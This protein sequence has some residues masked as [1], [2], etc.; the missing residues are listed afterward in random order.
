MSDITR[1]QFLKATA[2]AAAGGVLGLEEF[3]LPKA[4]AAQG[5]AGKQ[6][7]GDVIS[8]PQGGG[9]LRGIGETFKPDLFTGTANFSFPIATSP[10]REGFGP[11]L[12]LQYSSGNGNGLFGLGWTLSIP[13]VSRKTEKG[14]PTY[15]GNDTFL[16]SGSEDLVEL[17]DRMRLEGDFRVRTYRPRVEGLFARIER[18]DRHTG[19]SD[20]GLNDTF[21]RI[22]T[23]DG[24]SNLYGRT[25]RASVINSSIPSSPEKHFQWLLELT[26]DLKGNYIHYEY[27]QEDGDPVCEAIFERPRQ[28][29]PQRYLK[30]I[31]YGNVD[32]LDTSDANAIKRLLTEPRSYNKDFFMVVFDY[33]EHGH[34]DGQGHQRVGEGLHEPKKFDDGSVQKWKPRPDPFSSCRA[35]FEIRIYR[36][37]RRILM[38]HNAIP[39]ESEPILVKSTDLLYKPDEYTQVSCLIGATQRGYKKVA[40]NGDFESEEVALGQPGVRSSFYQI[41]SLP[42]LE[43]AY[44]EFKPHE[45]TFQ[46]LESENGDWPP[47]GLN[48]PNFALVSLFGQG[49]SD[50]MQTTPN[51][52]F[53]WRNQGQRK[54]GMRN[55]LRQ[56]PAGVALDQEGVG[57]GDMAGDGRADLLIHRGPHWGYYE[58]DWKGGWSPTFRKYKYQP[59]FQLHDPDTRLLDLTGDGKVDILRTDPTHFT[60]FPCKGQEGFGEPER[61]SRE[62]DS[63]KFP[64]IFFHDPR[65]RLACMAGSGLQDLVLVGSGRIDYWANHGHGKWGERITMKNAPRFGPDFDPKRLFFVDVDGNGTADLV[66]VDSGQVQFW[67]N[68]SGNGWSKDPITIHGTP[69]VTDLDSVLPA[70]MLGN[71]TQGLLFS[72]AYRGPGRSNYWFLDLTG[73]VKPYVLNEMSNNM[74]ATTK[75]QYSTSTKEYLEDHQHGNP[76]VTLLPFPVQVLKKV[77]VIDHFAKSKLVTTYRYH[78]GYYDGQEREFRGFGRVDHFD[79]ETFE[80]YHDASLHPSDSFGKVDQTMYSPPLETRTWFHQGSIADGEGGWKQS[81]FTKEF[82]GKD[83]SVL[84][85]LSFQA[86][87]ATKSRDALRALRGRMLRSELYALDG[88]ERQNRPYTVNEYLH[89]VREERNQ[90]SATAFTTDKRS[91]IFFPFTLAERTTQWERGDDP[92]CQFVFTEDFDEFGQ[93]RKQ[94]K[95]ACPRGWRS[96]SD[97]TTEP[98]LST[99][100]RIDY[101]TW[102]EANK[103]YIHDRVAR[104]TTFELKNTA[105]KNLAEL[106]DAPDGTSII[107]QK[108]NFYD[109]QEFNGLD[110]LEVGRF[111]ALVRTES[112]ALTRE[113]IQAAYGSE[114]PVYLASSSPTWPAEYPQEFR[115]TILS[116]AGYT[117]RDGTN[118]SHYASGFFAPTERRRYDFQENTGGPKRVLVTAK[119]DPLGNDTTITYDP[120]GFF[121]KEVKDAAK[122]RT[123]AEYDYLA[124]QPAR[125]L[126]P[127]DS[128]KSFNFTPLGLLTA[129]WVKGNNN[130]GDQQRPSVR[131][132]YDLWAFSRN[133]RPPSITTIRQVHH[134]TETDI[135]QPERD[136]TI[137]SIE[138]SD[139]F[140][141]L[142]QTRAQAED[143]M[144]GVLPLGT[145]VLPA[146]QSQRG[147]DIVGQPQQTGQPRVVVSGFQVYDNKS[148]VVEK[149]EA[150]F[151]DGWDCLDD[152]NRSVGQKATMFY[153]PRGQVIKTVN[154][155]G[156][157]QRVI[158]GIPGRTLNGN[159]AVD[160]D[161]PDVFEP[162]PWEAYTYDSNDN[163]SRTHPSTS[164]SYRHHWNTPSSV[165]IDALGRTIQTSKRNRA[166]LPSNTAA[167][168]SI[169]EFLTRSSYDIQGNL[170]V[171]E[172][173]LGRDAFEYVY[174]IANRP[175]CLR[176]TDAGIRISVFDVAGNLIEQRDGKGATVLHASD[177]LNRPTRLWA[178][179]GAA[180]PVTLRGRLEYGDKCDGEKAADENRNKYRL[181]KLYRHY[182]EAGL[183]TFEQY[184]FK[185]N[186]L[187]K[188]RQ[189]ISD[190]AILATFN[191]PPAD[192]AISAF[193]VNWEPTSGVKFLDYA[194]GLLDSSLY[195]I[196][197]AFDA[198]NRTKV[199]Q[200]PQDVE[201]KRK[202]GQ[203]RYSYRGA[204]E[205]VHF[206]GMVYVDRIAYNAKG[207]RLLISYGNG[208]M[209][210]YAY[211]DQTFRLARMRTEGYTKP[212]QHTYHPSGPVLQDCAYTYDLVGNVIFIHDRTPGCGLQ[213]QPDQ[214]DRV[215][216]YDPLYR[217]VS[218]TGR[219]CALMQQSAPWDDAPKCHDHNQTRSY[220][221]IYT[222]DKAGNLTQLG[223]AAGATESFNRNVTL[224]SGTNRVATVSIGPTK[225]IYTYDNNGNIKN[226][227]S[228]RH[229]EWDHSDR[230]RTY[231]TQTPASEPS[232][233]V[234]YFY[235]GIGQ[236]VKKVVRKQRNQGVET[237]IYVDGFF[238]HHKAIN[239]GA[240]TE[241]NT[242]HIM[243]NEKRIATIRIGT[244]L[245]RDTTPAVKYHLSD[246]LHCSN[247]V[248]ND[249]GT[250][251]NREEYFPYGET[252][253]GSFSRKR[254]R[255][256]GKESDEESALCYHGAR[257]YMRWLGRWVSVDPLGFKEDMNL[258]AFCKLNPVRYSDLNGMQTSETA[259]SQMVNNIYDAAVTKATAEADLEISRTLVIEQSIQKNREMKII[260]EI[261]QLEHRYVEITKTLNRNRTELRTLL[262][263]AKEQATDLPVDSAKSMVKALVKLNLW[264]SAAIEAGDLAI[265]QFMGTKGVSGSDVIGGGAAL[266]EKKVLDPNLIANPSLKKAADVTKD[267]AYKPIKYGYKIGTGWEEFNKTMN[268]IERVSTESESLSTERFNVAMKLQRSRG[269]LSSVASFLESLRVEIQ[270]RRSSYAHS[271]S[272]LRR[273]GRIYQEQIS[274]YEHYSR[275]Y[276]I[277]SGD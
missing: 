11:S 121:P 74:G 185:G 239:S 272:F 153:D 27:K 38:F 103:L 44:T 49:L 179:D 250:W 177:C 91:P 144:L 99:R 130:E 12:T 36:R 92:M 190:T 141:R 182:D 192:W 268:R 217:L 247:V 66:Y 191:A 154:P 110:Y 243:D 9:A 88:S 224:V 213:P 53:F 157:E 206:D 48:A 2:A 76:W 55:V 82:W 210:R 230:L 225:V 3:S 131:M 151:S 195:Q 127:N 201:G 7:A 10:G 80:R 42:P 203:F 215:F 115:G 18:W 57:F 22:T 223:H 98:F 160:L 93:A 147:G 1:R 199:I 77:E 207:Q 211:D 143:V 78:H 187:E 89:E 188:V 30:R 228:S 170:L 25:E 245:P 132:D 43:F 135:L 6:R 31:R 197:L 240:S 234:H 270:N 54:L 208:T 212:S 75:V 257:Y 60:V 205:Q 26:Y 85:T 68:Q 113:I 119:R 274:A 178:R 220:T 155:D 174:D 163:A 261:D 271:E 148:R 134:D 118:P 159:W 149:Y 221:Q 269:E 277:V 256:N 254:Y 126:D 39:G 193:R 173:S 202:K 276:S 72:M 189:V 231:R 17:V 108:L 167:P 20:T 172:D 146:D 235:D 232:V 259:E 4:E 204:L 8:L 216:S 90:G 23:K 111:G 180:E 137:E 123:V 29:H 156:S 266:V 200:Y 73:G 56:A 105:G 262:D 50:I 237:T 164:K 65:V 79:T 222:Y 181:G 116:R 124:L 97:R 176:S 209:T 169:E 41:Q 112:L 161:N 162:T 117:E 133:S 59:T 150:F 13:Q 214:L 227:T 253:F 218:A 58:A 69:V 168:P 106:K 100:T 171:A 5:Q 273:F 255:W 263:V 165:L 14:I 244:P 87:T 37:C 219:E 15:N 184:D 246:H 248:I 46:P 102:G 70:D 34:V 260:R 51:G 107:S 265:D 166:Q 83:P 251:I 258:Y 252:S 233:H 128:G 226:E 267:F 125:V 33:G 86:S 81:D 129:I 158:Y 96:L 32:P 142:L 198:L 35:G 62:F 275:L 63:D 264:A 122:L 21:W 67:F 238:E 136:E 145:G 101:A 28:S 175:V 194:T 47:Q 71:G 229:L 152:I 114:T 196:T 186:V 52:F 45:Q 241:N 138:C 16:L 140:G 24:V 109:G 120:L 236:R 249:A 139:G 95:V 61:R 183:L 84:A 40:T 19:N 94:T 104:T 64:N 242:L